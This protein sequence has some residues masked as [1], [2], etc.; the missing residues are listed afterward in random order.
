V[1]HTD[2][3]ERNF[4][5][6]VWIPFEQFV[7]NPTKK[8]QLLHSVD[9]SGSSGRVGGGLTRRKC[10]HVHTASLMQNRPF[11]SPLTTTPSSQN[12]DDCIRY[13]HCNF[14]D[15]VRPQKA[16]ALIGSLSRFLNNAPAALLHLS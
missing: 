5:S 10:L 3:A 1:Y 16:I 2:S 8:N 12:S 14:F 7:T 15:H 11:P 4:A 13:G 6:V 9:S